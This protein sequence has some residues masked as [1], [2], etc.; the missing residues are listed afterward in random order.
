VDRGAQLQAAAALMGWVTLAVIGAVTFAA[1]RLIGVPRALGWFAA[2]ALMLGATGYALQQRAGLPGHPVAADADPIDVDPGMVAFRGV[3]MPGDAPALAAADDHLR[4]G[5]ARGAVQGLLRAIGEKPRDAALW[6]GLGSALAA[7][8]GGQVS[9][10]AQFAFRRAWQLAPDQPGP[11]FFLGLAYVQS[12]ELPAAKAAWV[13]A[14][15]LAPRD[16][17]YRVDIAERLVL[18][19]EFQAMAAGAQPKP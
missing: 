7:H 18:I 8:D 5:D 12:G 13:R 3:I 17:A 19:D 11:P 9:P 4:R 10:A 6:T 14:L 1:L 16:A 15:R 2:A